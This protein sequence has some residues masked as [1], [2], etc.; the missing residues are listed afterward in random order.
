MVEPPI[1][2]AQQLQHGERIL[3]R[4]QVIADCRQPA[5]QAIVTS[6]VCSPKEFIDSFNYRVASLFRPR[7]PEIFNCL[8]VRANSCF[9][10][11]LGQERA[12]GRPLARGTGALFFSGAGQ[13]SGGKKIGHARVHFFQGARVILR[14]RMIGGCEVLDFINRQPLTAILAVQFNQRGRERRAA[15]SLS[16]LQ[17]C[18][19]AMMNRVS[20]RFFNHRL[21]EHCRL[22]LIQQHKLRIDV[23]FDRKLMQ[24][25]RTKAVNRRDHR[26]FQR[27]LVTQ[28]CLPFGI[29]RLAQ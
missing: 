26:S 20:E 24:Q 9:C 17:N 23:G 12:Q 11:W 22:M 6:R 10:R 15:G 14:G 28:P 18:F 7:F 3:L 5:A 27:P 8:S 25:P 1:D 13:G 16:E 2:F 29:G 4:Q 19:V 21:Q